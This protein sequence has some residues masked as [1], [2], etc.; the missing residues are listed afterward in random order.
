MAIK[1][2]K[3]ILIDVAIVAIFVGVLYAINGPLEMFPTD[4]QQGKARIGAAIIIV[5][6]V[7]VGAIGLLIKPKYKKWEGERLWKQIT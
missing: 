6:G 1:I 2:L 5:S 4:E 7:I 3:I